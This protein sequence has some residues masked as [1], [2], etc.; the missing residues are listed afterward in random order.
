MS[1]PA[2]SMR[3]LPSTGNM[4]GA[5]STGTGSSRSLAAR[6]SSAR[7]L[8]LDS[9]A[10]SARA[11]DGAA[12]GGAT[13]RASL[14]AFMGES[15][16]GEPDA[17][18]PPRPSRPPVIFVLAGG[19]SDVAEHVGIETHRLEG[20]EGGGRSSRGGG[21]TPV[22][23]WSSPSRRQAALSAS[24]RSLVGASGGGGGGGGGGSGFPT[25]S[26]RSLSPTLS[27]STRS[28]PGG[29]A[30]LSS[31]GR[32][33]AAAAG[34]G[35][36]AAASSRSGGGRVD[37]VALAG[38]LRRA[39]A[40]RTRWRAVGLFV[41][42]ALRFAG[43]PAR[44]RR[45]AAEAAAAA[46]LAR[47]LR[48]T[49]AAAPPPRAGEGAGAEEGAAGAGGGAEPSAPWPLT[50]QAAIA[51]CGEAAARHVVSPSPG[52]FPSFVTPALLIG[53]REDAAD[54][55]LLK[56]LGVTHVLNVAAHCPP[57]QEV[58]DAFIHLHIPLSDTP[59][60]DMGAAFAAATTFVGDAVRCGGRVLVH[61]V[62]GISRS[63][64]VALA[65]FTCPSGG[66][67]PL[68]AAWALVKRRRAA[69]L[70]NTGFR[71]QLALFE[72]EVRG[73]ASSVADLEVEE[74]NTAA[75]RAHPA[76]QRVE[77]I[78]EEAEKEAARLGLHGRA[79]RW[80]QGAWAAAKKAA[81]HAIRALQAAARAL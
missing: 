78:R 9:P 56:R 47:V 10:R 51:C 52:R 7:V 16:L 70:P 65:Y 66:D 57:P 64:A 62:A 12:G 43:A 20:E 39:S 22:A 5:G 75:W 41:R 80:M 2:Q 26:N 71:L 54:A 34:G 37:A 6:G 58:L 19:G 55:F 73:G 60:Q 23:Q 35:G 33:L 61:C 76:R 25:L 48:R 18:P 3:S 63:V 15:A 44:S 36:G 67:L 30:P 50:I 8:P 68:R 46:K 77:A 27:H 4:S 14:R 79:A 38:K 81:L 13:Q 49:G 11:L 74:W 40:A 72:M 17:P 29:A 31:S 24:G 45:S 42:A 53:T 1:I 21:G 59:E 28:L 32:S 69:A